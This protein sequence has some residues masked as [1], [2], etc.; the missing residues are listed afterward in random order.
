MVEQTLEQATTMGA[1]RAVALCRN[2]GGLLSFQAGRWVEAE[3]MLREAV[4]R[5]REL[6]AATGESSSLQRLGS[7]LTARGAL[8]EGMSVLGES[9]V[10]GERAVLRA[11]CLTR[12]YATMA[13]N[14]LAAG[15]LDAADEHMQHGLAVARRHGNCLTCNALILPESVQ[16]HL[17]KGRLEEALQDVRVLEETADRFG[18]LAWVA[19]ARQARGRYQVANDERDAARETFAAAE[20]A[21][22]EYGNRYEAV[23]CRLARAQVTADE[24]E[25]ERLWQSAQSALTELGS[26]FVEGQALGLL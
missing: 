5:Y 7:L 24:A 22:A 14:R 9:V 25:R 12:S 13:R 3:A 17:G 21:Y 2:F 10:T 4:D 6:A 16:V 23:R 26:N 20:S 1:P 11:H 18:S 19:M 15:D 8:D